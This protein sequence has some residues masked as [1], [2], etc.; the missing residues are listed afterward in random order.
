MNLVLLQASLSPRGA[1]KRRKRAIVFAVVVE[2]LCSCMCCGV[3]LIVFEQE[4]S[5]VA[6]ETRRASLRRL[7]RRRL[8]LAGRRC[9]VSF[10]L[11]MLF[12]PLRISPTEVKQKQY[13]VMSCRSVLVRAVGSF[14]VPVPNHD[15]FVFDCSYVY[16]FAYRM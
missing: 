16:V 8:L 13:S 9:F 15:M 14:K 2:F 3:L 10:S 5:G 4:S 12:Q 7:L 1:D 6:A 11:L